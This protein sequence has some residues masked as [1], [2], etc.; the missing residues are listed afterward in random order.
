VVADIVLMVSIAK[1]T[2]QKNCSLDVYL[3]TYKIKVS[4]THHRAD[5]RYP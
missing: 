2:P 4:N 3:M 5:I 1:L